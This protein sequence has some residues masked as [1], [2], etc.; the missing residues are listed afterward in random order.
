MCAA[1]DEVLDFLV[2]LGIP[3]SFLLVILCILA[4]YS[5]RRVYHGFHRAPKVTVAYLCVI[6]LYHNIWPLLFD[7]L[8]KHEAPKEGP[9]R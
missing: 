8:T 9:S 1:T 7:Y 2:R 6:L 4:F 3:P 5:W